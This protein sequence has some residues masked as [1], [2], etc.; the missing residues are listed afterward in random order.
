MSHVPVPVAGFKPSF[1]A[2]WVEYSTSVLPRYDHSFSASIRIWTLNLGIIS[3]VYHC[4]TGGTTILPVALG[5]FEPSIL[6][7]LV[8]C[9][10]NV[11]LGYKNSPSAVRRIQTLNLGNISWVFCHFANGVVP[12]S[13]CQYQDL[14]PQSWEYELSVLPLCYQGKTI[15]LL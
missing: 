6:V 11:L 8:K 14:N 4:A 3:Q 7:L 10:T 9:F 2:I 12:F 13:Q 1:L 15:I 5:G